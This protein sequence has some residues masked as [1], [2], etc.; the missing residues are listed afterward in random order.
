M[1]LERLQFYKT[2]RINKSTNSAFGFNKTKNKSF[3]KYNQAK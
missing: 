3:K 2:K 1:R